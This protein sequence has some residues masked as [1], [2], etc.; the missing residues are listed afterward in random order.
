MFHQLLLRFKET[1]LLLQKNKIDVNSYWYLCFDKIF[2]E[3]KRKKVN[4]LRIKLADIG[5]IEKEI[6]LVFL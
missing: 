2:N 5:I 6:F 3:W 4:N 1:I